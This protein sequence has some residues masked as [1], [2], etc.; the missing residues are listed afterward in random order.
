[1]TYP[2]V[3]LNPLQRS[4]SGSQETISSASKFVSRTDLGTRPNG[5]VRKL[6]TSLSAKRQ[7]LWDRQAFGRTPTRAVGVLR[8]RGYV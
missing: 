4:L 1:M 7:W 2:L 3:Y 5:N 8:V 6:S